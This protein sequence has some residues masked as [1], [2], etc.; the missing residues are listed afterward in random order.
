MA[1]E[2]VNF[3]LAA[4]LPPLAGLVNLLLGMLSTDGITPIGAGLHDPVWICFPS[5]DG[6]SMEQSSVNRVRTSDRK[7]RN[8]QAEI[9]EV[10]L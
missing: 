2:T 1:M 7:I 3:W 8:R 9:D 5:G 10:I 4:T 6:V